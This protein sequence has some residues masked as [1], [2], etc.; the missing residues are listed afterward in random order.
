MRVDGQGLGWI[1]D[2]WIAVIAVAVVIGLFVWCQLRLAR[3][4]AARPA[5]VSARVN[6]S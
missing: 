2:P 1:T 3:E 5:T 6:P 4:S